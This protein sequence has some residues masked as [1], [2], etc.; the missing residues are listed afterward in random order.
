M[1]F[2]SR[3]TAA[4]DHVASSAQAEG[5]IAVAR[6]AGPGAPHRDAQSQTINE[7]WR[8]ATIHQVDSHKKPQLENTW[9][10]RVRASRLR[11]EAAA[12][13]FR[14]TWGEQF[15]ERLTADPTFAIQQARKLE[16]A[17][18]ADYVRDLKIFTD[19]ILHDKEPPE[20]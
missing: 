12:K 4:T 6:L 16:S 1:D 17:A 5:G 20:S 14:A 3:R 15:E 18:L 13:A 2:C 7:R 8:F 19:L 10:E 11:Y 9:R